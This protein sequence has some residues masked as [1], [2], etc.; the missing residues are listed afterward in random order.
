MRKFRYDIDVSQHGILDKTAYEFMNDVYRSLYAEDFGK[1]VFPS[2]RTSYQR[3]TL[4]HKST[5]EKITIDFNI[6]AQQ[7]RE[8]VET[9]TMKNLVIVEFKAETKDSPTK[10]IFDQYGMVASKPCS[11][12]CLGNYFLGNV[13]QRDRFQPTIDTIKTIMY[14]DVQ[15][16][17]KPTKQLKKFDK[18]AEITSM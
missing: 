17:K 14:S 18:T 3:C 2:L 10:N 6:S 4:V 5:A 9:F 1:F 16:T 12:Y 15:V 8:S 13:Q 11:K 7:V